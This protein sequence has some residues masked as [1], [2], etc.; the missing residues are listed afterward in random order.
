MLAS[1][2]LAAS[3]PQLASADWR[4]DRDD[5]RYGHERVVR[6]ESHDERNRYCP[7]DTRGGVALV[8]QRSRAA[9]IPG[10]TWGY[11][12]RGIWVTHGCR[13]EFAVGGGRGYRDERRG[14]WGHG[15]DDRYGYGARVVRCES[16]DER[17]KFCRVPG[18][19]RDVDVQRVISRAR[20][21]YGYSWGFRRDG[22]WV[23]RGC[24]ADFVVF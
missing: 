11:D 20:C 22:V 12:R 13:A 1:M 18:G 2:L 14:D 15:R 6:C 19:V 7:V 4:H 16:N 8:R 17:S 10:R 5:R 23:D 9:C 24:R 21:E 3:V